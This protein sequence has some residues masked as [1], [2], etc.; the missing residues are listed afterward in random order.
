MDKLHGLRKDGLI[1]V[2]QLGYVARDEAAWLGRTAEYFHEYVAYEHIGCDPQGQ[3]VAPLSSS[4][5]LVRQVAEIAQSLRDQHR[6]TWGLIERTSSIVWAQGLVSEADET[7]V[8]AELRFYA[9][10][11]ADGGDTSSQLEAALKRLRRIVN[12]GRATAAQ[13]ALD[14]QALGGVVAELARKLAG[15]AHNFIEL[16]R[17]GRSADEP[18]RTYGDDYFLPMFGALVRLSAT[19]EWV[20]EKLDELRRLILQLRLQADEPIDPDDKDWLAGLKTFAWSV[21][22][23]AGAHGEVRIVA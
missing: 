16:A 5:G 6:R 17:P 3:A 18:A 23:A 7:F 1:A 8:A 9:K 2:F 12:E 11:A 13:A 22:G 4:L 21:G 15:D 10:S 19:I 14:D 20:V